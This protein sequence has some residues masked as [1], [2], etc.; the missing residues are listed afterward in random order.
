VTS[1]LLGSSCHGGQP[2]TVQWLDDGQQPLLNTI[3]ECTVGLYANEEVLVQSI[4]PI[5]VSSTHSFQFTPDPNAGPN[6]SS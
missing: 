5:D 3:G 2:C 1:P 4:R 6:S